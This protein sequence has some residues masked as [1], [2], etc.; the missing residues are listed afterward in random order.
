MEHQNCRCELLAQSPLGHVTACPGCGQV[1]LTLQHMTLRFEVDAFRAM[2]AMLE[3]ALCRM[4]HT[5][6]ATLPEEQ[7]A[8]RSVH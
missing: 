7:R 6:P 4:D 3:Q 1:H 8:G 5:M 2:A